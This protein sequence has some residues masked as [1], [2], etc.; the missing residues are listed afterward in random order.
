MVMIKIFSRECSSNMFCS[1]FYEQHSL[2]MLLRHPG[3]VMWHACAPPSQLSCCMCCHLLSDLKAGDTS[4][5]SFT[6]LEF[7]LGWI[8][9]AADYSLIFT[10]TDVL[11]IIVVFQ[12]DS[13]TQWYL[14]RAVTGVSTL[15]YTIKLK[16]NSSPAEFVA[17]HSEVMAGRRC[18]WSLEHLE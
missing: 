10:C 5:W 7:L 2:R 4:L 6:L 18:L 9:T 3:G 13:L 12:K 1:V 14:F 16:N 11:V 17:A 15:I 8:F